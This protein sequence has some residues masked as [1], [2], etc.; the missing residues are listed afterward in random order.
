MRH[1]PSRAPKFKLRHYLAL[2]ATVLFAL[3]LTVA[4]AQTTMP[5]L[6]IVPTVLGRF[7]LVYEFFDVLVDIVVRAHPENE[8][9][10]V[11]VWLI[12]DRARLPL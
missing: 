12:I 1:G 5:S 6:P 2:A 7:V 3:G 8:N 4:R 9:P 11:Q 10:S